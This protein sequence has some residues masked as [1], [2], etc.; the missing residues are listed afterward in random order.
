MK[1]KIKHVKTL[2]A[3]ICAG[4]VANPLITASQP[5][6]HIAT[7]DI[8]YNEEE[9]PPT[10]LELSQIIKSMISS[11]TI[12]TFR[13]DIRLRGYRPV[14][15]NLSPFGLELAR[16]FD[17]QFSEL[18]R[19]SGTNARTL[20]FDF[21]III[22]DGFV[23][24]LFFCGTTTAAEQHV[25]TT[26][27]DS[28]TRRIVNLTDITGVNGINLINQVLMPRITANPSRFN[29]N[30]TGITY[31][32]RFVIYDTTVVLT[33]DEFELTNTRTGITKIDIPL[34]KITNVTA[35]PETHIKLTN[36]ILMIQLRHIADG[37]GY[38]LAWS[39]IP[40]TVNITSDY[41]L[42]IT[43]TIGRNSYFNAQH[44]GPLELE[45]APVI[46]NSLT[47]LPLSFFTQI[48]GFV[49]H[50]DQNGHITFSRFDSAG[51]EL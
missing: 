14:V 50:I 28:A 5:F 25:L 17:A 31:Q 37:F 9:T 15:T 38:T 21:E 20:N 26:V 2:A 16:R 36:G 8:I 33:F 48:M 19:L 29:T 47:Y 27:I 44:P 39:E 24:I 11:Q 43:V 13:G 51:L 30:F 22:S 34:E 46:F 1:L 12:N 18:I 45:T 3:V 4:L 40:R 10:P 32:Q 23:N 41:G 35:I 7:T 6:V 49:H 42:S